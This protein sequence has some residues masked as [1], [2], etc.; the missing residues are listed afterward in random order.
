M[1]NWFPLHSY[2]FY[3]R[4]KRTGVVRASP[5]V[6]LACGFLTLIALG[7]LFLMLP[8]AAQTPIGAM[9]AL[10]MATSAVTITGLGVV[11]PGTDLTTFGQVV[12]MVLVQL[13]GLGYVTF[14]VV[15][16]ITL[17]KR[18]SLQHQAL[19]LE[20]FNQTS[21]SK[22]RNTAFLVLRTSVLVELSVATILAI[23]WSRDFP[24]MK[25]VYYGV[26]HAVTAFNNSGLSLFSDSLAR[27]VD[28]PVTVFTI[29]A[30]IITGGIGFTVIGD[31]CTTRKWS[32]LRPYTRTMI[33]GTLALNLFGFLAILALEHTNPATL[34]HLSW[35][36]QVL[37]AWTQSV[38]T[39]TAGFSSIDIGQMRDSSA[40]VMMFLMFIGGGSLS[41]SGGIK[42]GTFIVLLA[43]VRAYVFHRQEVVLFNRTIS[44]STVQKSLALLLINV[45]LVFTGTLLMTIFEKAHFVDLLFEVVS[46]L[47]TTGLSRGITASLSAPG[48]IVLVLLMFAGR[49]GPLTLAYSIATQRRSR[50]RYPEAEFQVG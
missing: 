40:L 28:D 38:V 20:A 27:F 36:G 34:G 29:T 31:L 25:A 5:P 9:S 3:I 1:R 14:A 8:A 16:A 24:W 12:L 46:A 39:R 10:F 47:S 23:W 15:S 43:A 6:V 2:P 18:M 45:V 26:F 7:T 41:L 17:G 35:D 48:Q 4:F 21:V 30:A 49:V 32:R 42:V 50:V 11:D 19:A 33:V 22:V 37:A 44:S 13:G